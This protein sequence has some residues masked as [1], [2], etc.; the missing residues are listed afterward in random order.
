MGG[1]ARKG[2]GPEN[3]TATHT[4]RRKTERKSVT[5]GTMPLVPL[6]QSRQGSGAQL[7]AEGAPQPGAGALA[8]ATSA[9]SG[10]LANASCIWMSAFWMEH[11]KAKFS[12]NAVP[13]ATRFKSL[14]CCIL[15]TLTC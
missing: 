1:G 8:L 6:V 3:P 14:N 5:T 13:T 10:N 2:A 7:A 11:G 12:T 4:S 9:F 15:G